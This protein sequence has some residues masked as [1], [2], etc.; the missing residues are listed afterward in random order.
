MNP[1]LKA[2]IVRILQPEG[3]NRLAL[4]LSSAPM[5]SLSRVPTSCRA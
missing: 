5:V 1:D 4:V 2:G 3:A